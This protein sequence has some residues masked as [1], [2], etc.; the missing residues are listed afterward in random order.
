MPYTYNARAYVYGYS[1][2]TGY[3]IQ[4]LCVPPHDG[5]LTFSDVKEFDI[6][7]A[8]TFVEDRYSRHV[9]TTTVSITEE[10]KC[11][12]AVAMSIVAAI[13]K[14]LKADVKTGTIESSYA[15]ATLATWG[16]DEVVDFNTVIPKLMEKPIKREDGLRI[17]TY[18]VSPAAMLGGG[19]ISNQ[20]TKMKYYEPPSAVVGEKR[21]RDESAPLDS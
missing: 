3:E 18:I 21:V 14:S 8:L 20:R 9:L 12:G 15:E 5:H 11:H 1:D 16:L 6:S 17:L 7:P 2:E 10:N 4:V 19:R 13:S